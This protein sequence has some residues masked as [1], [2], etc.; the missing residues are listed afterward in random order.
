MGSSKITKDGPGWKDARAK[1]VF[2]Q[3]RDYLGICI[4]ACFLRPLRGLG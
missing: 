2:M 4:C 1:K 3:I